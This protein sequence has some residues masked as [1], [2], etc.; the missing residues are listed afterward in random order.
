MRGFSR[1][2]REYLQTKNRWVVSVPEVYNLTGEEGKEFLPK[3]ILNNQSLED[4]DIKHYQ[5]SASEF[6]SSI[7]FKCYNK[8][9]VKYNTYGY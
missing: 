7:S 2:E 4:F 5:Y 8:L 1:K 6:V 3:F 9:L